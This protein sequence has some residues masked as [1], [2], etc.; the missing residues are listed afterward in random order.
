MQCL[1]KETDDS[2]AEDQFRCHTSGVCIPL[3]SKCDE[4][5]DCRDR[6][7]EENCHGKVYSIHDYNPKRHGLFISFMRPAARKFARC[8]WPGRKKAYRA[9]FGRQSSRFCEYF[10]RRILGLS[11]FSKLF[12]I[13]D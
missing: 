4:W 8:L 13:T 9:S 2:C 5:D 7:D 6:S 1:I 12:F 3:V 10:G 11:A